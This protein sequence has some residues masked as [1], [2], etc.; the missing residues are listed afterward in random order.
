MRSRTKHEYLTSN[1]FLQCSM[2]H[3]CEKRANVC[4]DK[5]KWAYRVQTLSQELSDGFF[6]WRGTIHSLT[7]LI[8]DIPSLYE[9]VHN[10]NTSVTLLHFWNKKRP[11]C[12]KSY[13]IQR[14]QLDLR[15]I[16]DVS[17]RIIGECALPF[18]VG[19]FSPSFFPHTNEGNQHEVSLIL[20]SRGSFL[21]EVYY[22]TPFKVTG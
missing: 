6:S 14:D 2:S 20:S 17:V 8:C 5:L 11:T 15:L 3:A 4:R 10:G 19:I 1:S 22:C 21:P 18:L 13:R 16:I 9:R 12:R 7:W